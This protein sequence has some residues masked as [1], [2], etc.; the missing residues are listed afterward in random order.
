MPRAIV[1]GAGVIGASAAV[2]ARAAG[3]ETRLIAETRMSDAAITSDP[4]FASAYAAA[5][6]VPHMVAGADVGRLYTLSRAVFEALRTAPAAGVRLRRHYEVWEEPAPEPAYLHALEGVITVAEARARGEPVPQRADAPQGRGWAFDCLFADMPLYRPWLDAVVARADIAVERRRLRADDVARLEADV[7]INALGVGSPELF[8]ELGPGF[9]MRG[10]L[11]EFPSDKPLPAKASG[12]VVSYNYF[13]ARACYPEPGGTR[14][15]DVYCYP[16]EKSVLCGGLRQPGRVD[17]VT[18]RF[19]GVPLEGPLVTLHGC[20]V[21]EAMLTLNRAL[22]A[23]LTGVRLGEEF[24][25]LEG[26]RYLA[27]EPGAPKLILGPRQR[28][29]RLVV[30]AIGLGG[31]GVTLS[32]GV[33]LEAVAQASAALG[34]PGADAAALGAQLGR[35][36]AQRL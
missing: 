35:F 5:S 1:L 34:E 20:Q 17:P 26:Y 4:R 14:S 33:A 12:Q 16:R 9:I 21:P 11:L 23:T 22:F 3:F 13:P 7:V 6:I 2:V 31:A 15:G 8:P 32:W 29:G 28:E 19:E 36:L 18:G 27:G 30:D 10:L 24:R 25:V